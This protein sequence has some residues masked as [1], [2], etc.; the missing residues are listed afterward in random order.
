[1]AERAAE[2]LSRCVRELGPS[3]EAALHLVLPPLAQG[4]GSTARTVQAA[5]AAAVA[6][7]CDA[8]SAAALVPHVAREVA[9]APPRARPMFAQ[10][11]AGASGYA[12]AGGQ[13]GG[14]APWCMREV[15][16]LPR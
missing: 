13:A 9:H 11:L 2:A 15:R 1:M 14:Q 7:V 8:T 10:R 12:R 5:A 3:V 6:E 16:S 4:A